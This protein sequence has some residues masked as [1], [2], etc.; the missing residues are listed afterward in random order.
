[1]DGL[2]ISKILKSISAEL[3][4]IGS[5]AGS[6]GL[7]RTLHMPVSKEE[8][9]FKTI[10]QVM[11]TPDKEYTAPT[12]GTIN[13]KLSDLPKL[14]GGPFLIK[15]GDCILNKF[16]VNSDEAQLPGGYSCIQNENKS[17]LLDTTRME[18]YTQNEHKSTVGY[19]PKTSISI[20]LYQTLENKVTKLH[21]PTPFAA[22]RNSRFSE[23]FLKILQQEVRNVSNLARDCE[24]V[25]LEEVMATTT[26]IDTVCPAL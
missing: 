23:H 2:N 13:R 17:V 24:E 8:M 9:S 5:C 25:S 11:L 18:I 15:F 6:P 14:Q 3:K 16:S 4:D 1:M 12:N 19:L 20:S 10:A 7:S 22:V 21:N 26:A